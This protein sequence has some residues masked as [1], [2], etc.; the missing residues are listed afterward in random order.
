[1]KYISEFREKKLVE[2]ISRKIERIAQ[3]VGR[4]VKLMEV[5]GTHA[6]AILKFGIRQLIPLSVKLLSGPG[7]PVC[8]T[9]N[10]YIDTAC[11]YARKGFLIATFG[12]MMKVPGS[13]GSLSEEKSKGGKVKVVYSSMD[14]LKL[15]ASFPEE[16]VV[17]LGIGFETT[18]PTVAASISLARQQNIKNFMVLCGHKLIP[19][20][21]KALVEADEV[22]I[23]GFLCPGHVSSIIGSK[24]YEFIARDYNIPC[25]VAGFEP[26]DILQAIYLLLSQICHGEAK[27][28]NEYTRVVTP[29]GNLKAKELMAKVF[30]LNS[31]EWRGIGEI[32]DSGL[33]LAENYAFYDAQ[34]R[35]PVEIISSR[36]MEGC[37][38]GEVLRGLIEPEE[39]SLFGNFCNPSNPSGPCMV[40]IEGACNIYYRFAGKYD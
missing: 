36:E 31:S 11:A 40:S 22:K 21:M 37:R 32:E 28:E 24:A 16:R 2:H 10:L 3:D 33:S 17:F 9:P 23:D 14:A 4:K 5:C 35:F 8:V 15:A 6:M 7:C 38:C 39:C 34:L 25:V 20:A 30:N 29:Q 13:D 18:A 1:M 26:V 19:P 27:V 12:D